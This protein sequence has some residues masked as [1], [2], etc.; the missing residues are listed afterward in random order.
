M[1][2]RRAN[3]E[4]SISKRKD[5]RYEAAA[6][7]AT[8]SG[9]HRRIRVYAKTRDEVHRRLLTQLTLAKQGIP[10]PDQPWR[11]DT[12]LDYW[13]CQVVPVKTRPRTAEQ[14]ES[15]VRLHLKP[16]L[17]SKSLTKLSVVDVQT[18][19]NDQLQRGRSVRSIQLIRAVLRAALSRAQREE[20]VLRNVAKLVDLPAWERKPIQPWNAEEASQFLATAK[21][22]RWYP[23]YAM[24]LLYGMRRGEV[25]GLRWCDVDFTRD[26]V[27]IRQQLQRVGKTLEQGPVKTAAGRRDLPLIAMLREELT[28]QY[29]TQNSVDLDAVATHATSDEGLVFLSTSG[30]PIDPKNFVRT[31]HQ[32]R[33]KADLPGSSIL[34]GHRGGPR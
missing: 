7:V 19:I 26:Q 20:L 33:G 10:A 22:H 17:G 21:P 18:F 6:Y 15:V 27:R 32:I 4:G 23:A 13:L 14:Y 31:F 12:Y 16:H 30:T 5:G 28:H 24:L 2:S 34:G 11:V 25:L 3:G 1:T 9:K 29:A 8:V